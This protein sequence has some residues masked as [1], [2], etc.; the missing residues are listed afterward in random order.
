MAQPPKTAGGVTR[1]FGRRRK[2]EQKEELRQLILKAASEMFIE[3]GYY[4]FSMR[5][6]A[7]RIGY[8][9]ATLYLYFRDKDHLLFS[10][11]DD[12]FA[13]FRCELAQ[14]ASSAEDPETCL[15]NIGDAYI[16]FALTHPVY[17]QLM[18]MWRVDYLLKTRQGEEAPRMAAFQVLVDAVRDAQRKG[19]VKPG[20]PRMYS[21]LMWAVMHGVAALAIQMPMF[22]EERAARLARH[23]K[24]MLYLALRP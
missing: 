8:A 11:V 10:V 2:G 1:T 13:R 23:A 19:A 12:A 15:N 7:E 14:A 6:L 4:A 9:P 17:Y 3:Q 5:K 18:F 24:E 16:R 21:D 22:T 20:D